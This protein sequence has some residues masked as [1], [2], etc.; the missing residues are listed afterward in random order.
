MM[1]SSSGKEDRMDTRLALLAGA[2]LLGAPAARAQGTDPALA[3]SAPA[4]VESISVT[5]TGR[6]S[7][8]PDRVSFTAGVE[9][10]APTLAPAIEENNSRVAAVIAALKRAGATERD[11]RTSQ[12]FVSPQMDYSP[13]KR[14]RITGYQ[15]TN[16]VTVTRENPAE[17][18]KLLQA[19]LE[20]G[21]NQVS[22]LT[23]SVADASRGRD[24]GLQAAFADAR[25]RAQTLA[26]AAA[27]TLGRALTI[28]EGAAPMPPPRP[29][30]AFAAE[31]RAAQ[32]PV[33]SGSEELVFTVSVVF[34][35]R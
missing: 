25:A 12:L 27:R 33:E 19:A 22:G 13:G 16:Q 32:V 17:A 15:V 20:A 2:A 14:P 18:G 11:I 10:L 28:A 3:R 29:M 9:S 30:Q 1:G 35:M 6:V 31:A 26:R 7:V 24:E 4:L 8:K 23:F 5:G 34:E 21:A